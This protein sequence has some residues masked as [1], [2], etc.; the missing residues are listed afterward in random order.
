MVSTGVIDTTAMKQEKGKRM[1]HATQNRNSD[2]I[3]FMLSAPD[4]L[5]QPRSSFAVAG[6]PALG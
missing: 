2:A 1:S 5:P 6:S 4:T 3:L